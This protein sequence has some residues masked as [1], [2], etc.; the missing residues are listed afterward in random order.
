MWEVSMK[1]SKLVWNERDGRAKA[2]FSISHIGQL[3]FEVEA[4][5]P[6]QSPAECH[7]LA[8]RHAKLLVRNLASELER[9]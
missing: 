4:E 3:S 1:K 7:A 9:Q 6:G 5:L 2:A 8:L